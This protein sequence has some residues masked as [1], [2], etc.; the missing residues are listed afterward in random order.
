MRQRVR[1]VFWA[2]SASLLFWVAD[3]R[4]DLHADLERVKLAWAPS[5][6]LYELTPRLLE[7]GELRRL[8]L[9]QHSVD[10]S[11]EDCTTVLALGVPST[12][13]VLRSLPERRNDGP[14]D[15]GSREASVAGAAQLT[16]CGARKGML[17]R[18]AVEMRSPRGVI[19]FLVAQSDD[20][21]P[22]VLAALPHRD[23]GPP[24][25]RRDP[26]PAASL[27]D[28]SVR[29]QNARDRALREAAA[30]TGERKLS[31]SRHGT[32]EK[33][34]RLGA[35]CHRLDALGVASGE[36]DRPV[37]IDMVVNS[38]GEHEL[39][40]E[41]RSENADASVE[42][43]LGR[44]EIVKLTLQGAA[45]RTKLTLLRAT[46]PLPRG[47]PEYWG[48]RARARMAEAVGHARFA[49][50]DDSPVFA[51]LG[52]QG[53]TVLPVEVEPGACYLVAVAAIRGVPRGIALAARSVSTTA[54]NQTDPDT[55]DTAIAFCAEGDDVA[56]IE[57]EAR[58]NGLGFLLAGWQT[59][60][61][62]LG[63]PQQ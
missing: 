3:V 13:F 6:K 54:Q 17:A 25:R 57:I 20:P 5:A 60:R 46:W 24:A 28:L 4:A 18:L 16:R 39:L 61:V 62:R 55:G 9:R 33:L 53:A 58:G 2:T 15:R 22:S 8:M 44:S 42:F 50:L 26:G 19:E 49:A 10:A 51:S 1:S 23:P 41:D 7:R 32:A 29:I 59:G 52:V 35:G 63:A 56:V 21:V 38:V 31:A 11:T 47:L 12:N 48:A 43:C 34:L 27:P 37:D 14:F 45:P 30:S 36:E 40:G